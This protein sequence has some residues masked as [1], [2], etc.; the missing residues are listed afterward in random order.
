ME[1]K[2]CGAAP[3]RLNGEGR[4]DLVLLTHIHTAQLLDSHVASQGYLHF[5][6]A[7]TPVLR[8]GEE[9]GVGEKEGEEK[10]NQM[11]GWGWRRRMH[12]P[13]DTIY[14]QIQQR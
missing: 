14:R 1:R 12:S 4:R 3:R 6:L 9:R 2:E 10:E 11:G 7:W 5:H 13:T 8:E